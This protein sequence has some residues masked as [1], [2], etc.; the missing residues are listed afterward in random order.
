MSK[1][2]NLINHL[3]NILGTQRAATISIDE[4]IQIVGDNWEPYIRQADER[5]LVC[6]KIHPQNPT[7]LLLDRG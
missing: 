2:D 6:I 1:Q 5:L 3:K 4:V 7:L